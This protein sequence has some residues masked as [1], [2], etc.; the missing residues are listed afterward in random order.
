M[1]SVMT[2]RWMRRVTRPI[3]VAVA[4]VGALLVLGLATTPATAHA[5]LVEAS[6][7]D[8]ASLSSA[9]SKVVLTFSEN[10]QERF[11]QVSVTKADG[12]TVSSGEPSVDG[13]VVTQRLANAL[14]SGR[15]ATRF[16][17]VSEDGHPVSDTL[18]FSLQSTDTSTET[19]TD[20]STETTTESSSETSTDT[21]SET[22]TETPSD[23]TT[24]DEGSSTDFGLDENT[25]RLIAILLLGLLLVGG[26]VIGLSM[27]RDSHDDPGRGA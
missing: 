24:T 10:I 5:Q 8:G 22:A 1:M 15:Y 25:T 11:A 14:T 13:A 12:T 17:V 19:S 16:R 3:S 21:S 2:R 6:P 4:A 18:A 23:Q 27:S 20:T 9:P 26:L 7:A